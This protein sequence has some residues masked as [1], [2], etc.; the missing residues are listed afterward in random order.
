MVLSFCFYY[1][2]CINF[3]INLINDTL[4]NNSLEALI[5]NNNLLIFTFRVFFYNF[6]LSPTSN[7][8]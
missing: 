8:A 3:S 4:I 5:K 6:I 1:S 2:F 7:T